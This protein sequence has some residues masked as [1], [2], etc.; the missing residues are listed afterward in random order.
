MTLFDTNLEFHQD[1]DNFY[2]AQCLSTL[3][4]LDKN[5][6]L[7]GCILNQSLIILLRMCRNRCVQSLQ[8][9]VDN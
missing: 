9:L 1:L 3:K 7:Q 8:E 2:F 6:F 5:D 4:Q